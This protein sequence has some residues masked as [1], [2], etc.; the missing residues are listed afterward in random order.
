MKPGNCQKQMMV[1]VLQLLCVIKHVLDTKNLGLKIEHM[2]NSNKPWE[3]VYFC[4]CNCAGDQVQRISISGFML[5][6]LG[7]PVCQSKSQ[8]SV[9]LSSSEAE[10]IAL[11]EVV[12]EVMFMIQ[13]LESMKI[14]ILCQ[15]IVRVDNV[16]ALFMANNITTMLHTKHKGI[17]YKYVK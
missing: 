5:C 3:I 4:N 10:Y 6:V 16:G 1:Q 12:K 9:S 17:R 13:L 7:I 14:L 2:R 8:K 11:F 15:V